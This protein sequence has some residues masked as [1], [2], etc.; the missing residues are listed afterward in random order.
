MRQLID[1][2]TRTT[3]KGNVRGMKHALI[4][5]DGAADEPLDALDGQTPLQAANTP[6]IDWIALNG[7]IGTVTTVPEGMLPGSDV[8]TL[9]VVGYD[10][11]KYY[12]GR[13]PLEAAAQNLQI[14]PNDVLFR[15]N[16]TTIID[17]VMVDFSA[18]HISQAEAEVLIAELSKSLADDRIEFHPGVMYRHLMIL[19]DAAPYEVVCTPPHDIPGQPIGEYLPRGD[20]AKLIRELMQRSREILQHS[21]INQSRRDAGKLPVTSIWLW[22]QGRMPQLPSF[23]SRFG[24][25]GAC[26]AAVDLIRGISVLVGWPVLEVEGATGYVD[27]NYQGKGCRAVEALHEFDLVCVHIEAPDEAGHSG[28]LAAKVQ[29][30]EQIDEHI[31]GPVLQALKRFGDWKCLLLPDHATPVAKRTHTA[32]P[33]PFCMAGVGVGPAGPSTFSESN[34]EDSDLHIDP[35]HKLM[36]YFLSS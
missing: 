5:P 30:I 7:R 36:E 8:A 33:P 32:A 35:G 13:A 2:L 1:G 26:I 12:T 28:D 29:A 4:L 22:G 23:E 19:K 9:S 10:P 17:D 27:T 20:G 6:N 21:E 25:H 31:V 18:G 34:A 15:C 24:L 16:L 3:P 11:R 14:G